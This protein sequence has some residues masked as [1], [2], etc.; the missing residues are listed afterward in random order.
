[1]AKLILKG[2]IKKKWM[3]VYQSDNLYYVQDYNQKKRVSITTEQSD[4]S[5]IFGY[6]QNNAWYSLRGYRISFSKYFADWQ[7]PTKNEI[8]L[9]EI[10]TGLMYIDYYLGLRNWSYEG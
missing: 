3:R 9:F 2:L 8:V 5:L 6:Y 7:K 1:M 4:Y 10:E